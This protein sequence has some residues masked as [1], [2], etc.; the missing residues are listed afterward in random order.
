M[1]Q[2]PPWPPRGQGGYPQ[3]GG[4]YP[5]G[6]YPPQ[7][8][9]PAQSASYPG[10][11]PGQPQGGYR[12][13]RPGGPGGGYQ[14]PMGGPGG[15]GTG[16]PGPRKSTGMIIGIVV[17]AVVLLVAVGGILMALGRGG[18]DQPVT[19]ITPSTPTNP[20]PAPTTE[21]T[22]EPT[23]EPTGSAPTSSRPTN[24][25][26]QA[27]TG[28]VIDLG[29]GVTLIPASDW[30][31]RSKQQSAA[32]LAS[33]RDIF[34]G[35][36][37]KLPADSNAAQTCDG[38]HREL[39]EEYTNGKFADPKKVDLGTKKLRGASCMA[40][41]T[42]AN[43]GNAVNVLVYSL[44]SVRTDGLTVVGS[45]YFTEDSDIEALNQDFAA[46]VNSMLRTQ[47]VGG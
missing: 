42:L 19:T 3:H 26:T 17:A 33:G 10:G 14:P 1:S 43:G 40:E 44:V 37:A 20:S 9:F 30:H 23:E 46:M 41:V 31:L 11:V 21:A 38:Y 7:W 28:K 39:A 32:Q 45:L 6:G 29:S 24:E 22:T 8:G 2:N 4:G 15:G 13:Q 34:L 25:P 18:D 35:I 16:G 12:G 47:A 27:P 5:P 36:V